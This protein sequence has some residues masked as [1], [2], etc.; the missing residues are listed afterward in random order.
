MA[1]VF[2]HNSCE[3][4]VMMVVTAI[5]LWL[6]SKM[7][8]ATPDGGKYCLQFAPLV[9][10]FQCRCVCFD[11]QRACVWACLRSVGNFITCK[12][13]SNLKTIALQNVL[14]GN[15]PPTLLQNTFGLLRSSVFGYMKCV[16]VYWFW[17]QEQTEWSFDS[18]C[19][20]RT[21]NRGQ[22]G[23]PININISVVCMF[24]SSFTTSV[25][26]TPSVTTNDVTSTLLK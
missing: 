20:K 19:D 1:I 9:Y 13:S 25:H 17:L 16:N 11:I 6:F 24:G 22:N 12:H 5:S 14:S 10:I 4:G 7:G 26:S 2:R 18:K 8:W 3:C 21:W 15:P 23:T